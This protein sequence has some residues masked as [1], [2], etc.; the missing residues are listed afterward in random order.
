M[1]VQAGLHKPVWDRDREQNDRTADL[2]IP[3]AAKMEGVERAADLIR[4]RFGRKAIY[5]GQALR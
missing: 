5:N 3:T 2:L 4:A 1:Q